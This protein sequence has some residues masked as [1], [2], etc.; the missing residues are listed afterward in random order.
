MSIERKGDPLA[1]G[2][3][4]RARIV[5]FWRAVELFEPQKVERPDPRSDT[6]VHGVEPGLPLPWEAEHPV[7][8]LPLPRNRVRRHRVYLGVFQSKET[9]EILARAFGADPRPRD[10][11]PRGE[12]A[13]AA[14]EVDEHGQ[15]LLSSQ[16]LSTC[17]WAIGRT[18]SPGPRS[19]RWLEGFEGTEERFGELY[20]WLTAGPGTAPTKAIL[21]LVDGGLLSAPLVELWEA[22]RTSLKASA[23]VTGSLSLPEADLEVSASAEASLD[24]TA[25]RPPVSDPGEH[26][27]VLRYREL[28]ALLRVVSTLLGVQRHLHL[29][30]RVKSHSVHVKDHEAELEHQRFLLEQMRGEHDIQGDPFSDSTDTPILNS[31]IAQDLV[32]VSEAVRGKEYGRALRAYLSSASEIAALRKQDVREEGAEAIRRVHPALSPAGR[33]PAKDTHPLVLSQQIAVNTITG[34]LAEST[35]IL[36]VNGPPGTGKTTLLR[37]LVAQVVVDRALV[38]SKFT[39]PWEAFAGR[40][41]WGAGHTRV[42]FPRL[43]PELAGFEIVVASANNGAVDNVTKEIPSR[44]AVD[45][46]W[47]HADHFAATATNLLDDGQEAWGTLA[48]QLG[49][50]GNRHKF[51]NRFWW[52][53]RADRTQSPHGMRDLLKKLDLADRADSQAG[54]KQW[55]EAIATFRRALRERDRLVTERAEVARLLEALPSAEKR[56]REAEDHHRVCEESAARARSEHATAEKL[57]SES[58]RALREVESERSRHWEFKPGF[59]DVL[60]SLG[61]RLR[62]WQHTDDEILARLR[63]A[64][65]HERERARSVAETARAHESAEHGLTEAERRRRKVTE[66]LRSLESSVE[67]ADRRWPG[68]VPTEEATRDDTARE[69]SAPWS[70]PELTRARTEVFLA[71]LKLHESFVRAVPGKMAQV[72]RAATDALSGR[73]KGAKDEDVREA[74]RGL[75]LVVPVV[76][77]TFASFARTFRAFDSE[78]LGWLLVDE[79]GQATPQQVV[80]ALWRSQRAVVVGDPLQLEPVS[81]L[82]LPA[83]EHLAAHFRVAQRW[84]PAATSVQALSDAVT[85]L[86]TLLERDGGEPLW[87][88]SPLR[89]HRRCDDPMFT[90]SNSVAYGGMMVFGTPP[91]KELS[92][93][94]SQWVNVPASTAEGHWRPAEGDRLEWLLDGLREQY[95]HPMDDV[96]VLAPFRTVADQVRK[97]SGEHGVRFDRTGTIHTS[98]GK[99]A[100][101]VVFVLGGAL[102]RD[103]ALNWASQTPNLLNVAASRAK[104]RLYVIGD[105]QAWSGRF[106]FQVLGN[107]LPLR[108]PS[109]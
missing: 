41:G 100:S 20:D 27:R 83:Q 36:A 22:V 98:Q 93:P 9:D 60:F 40:T 57:H 38:L 73:A 66:E 7:R 17:G 90:I 87:V 39:K 96:F 5:D 52:G 82:S 23:E 65:E 107:H 35:G 43:R 84:L 46:R 51:V 97:I 58:D 42:A 48:A 91:R 69:L 44:E 72:L 74:M 3:R 68:H 15:A 13:L 53:N 10:E 26:G 64:K 67:Q 37:D 86:G 61:R 19:R 49:N 55:R 16:A 79:A 24:G 63:P 105:H 94:P 32:T 29:E 12:A 106:H 30:I 34:T 47:K 2:D 8:R 80:G 31:F 92:L 88:G 18:I 109:G 62:E 95:G 70:D 6:P 81:T 28:E 45:D 1:G 54:Q 33:W 4:E 25:G 102:N 59:W 21:S 76:S 78:S 103:G 89:V 108:K 77:S 50:A 104:R 101:V 14:F 11:R 75:F 56:V 85:P 71:A 99:E